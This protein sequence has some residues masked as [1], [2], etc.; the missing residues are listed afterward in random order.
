M[1]EGTTM[2]TPEKAVTIYT[3]PRPEPQHLR[4]MVRLIREYR[5]SQPS[6]SAWR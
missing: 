3:A 5:M 1:T 4:E 6:T 2:A